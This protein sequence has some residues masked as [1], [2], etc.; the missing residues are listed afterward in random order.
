MIDLTDLKTQKELKSC[1][2]LIQHGR[3][4]EVL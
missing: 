1:I 4:G 2:P 3:G